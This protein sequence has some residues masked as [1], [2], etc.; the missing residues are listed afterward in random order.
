MVLY[1]P[2]L[3]R[4]TFKPALHVELKPQ[5]Q[6]FL[7]Q[8]EQKFSAKGCTKSTSDKESPWREGVASPSYVDST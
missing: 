2:W 4:Q 1:H 3:E 6:S 5:V 7:M 8:I